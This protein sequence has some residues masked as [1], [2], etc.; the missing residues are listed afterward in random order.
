MCNS[1]EDYTDYMKQCR[2]R[3]R[4]QHKNIIQLYHA[5]EANEEN[6]CGDIN[7]IT[8]YFEYYFHD[9]K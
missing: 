7:K 4:I 8:I 1:S 5:Q 6:I 2:K 3:M 9:M